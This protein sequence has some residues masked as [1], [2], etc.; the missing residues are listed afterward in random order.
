MAMLEYTGVVKYPY[1]EDTQ[2]TREFRAI[3]YGQQE[4]DLRKMTKFKGLQDRI[5]KEVLARAD[6]AICTTAVLG[7][8][9]VRESIR[10]NVIVCDEA[11]QLA[12]PYSWAIIEQLQMKHGLQPAILLI[13]DQEQLK[14]HCQTFSI[15][16]IDL[17]LW[18]NEFARQYQMSPVQRLITAGRPFHMLR[19]QFRLPEVLT[20]LPVRLYYTLREPMIHHFQHTSKQQCCQCQIL[21]RCLAE[22]YQ[23]QLTAPGLFVSAK[24]A[25]TKQMSASKGSPHLVLEVVNFSQWFAERN[26]FGPVDFQII[27]PYKAQQELYRIA[28]QNTFIRGVSLSA[29]GIKTVDSFQGGLGNVTIVDLTYDESAISF[30]ASF[31]RSNV[32]MMGCSVGRIFV[33]NWSFIV[34]DGGQ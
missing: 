21:Q 13:G 18:G 9:W 24:D 16:K 25:E 7:R 12:E 28:F 6:V 20:E 26:I 14:P 4:V 33:G 19:D 34:N 2:D 32:A 15:L 23:I 29:I 10:P 11:C 27:G 17:E 3:W 22:R 1:W 30:V 8:K 5:R 31:S